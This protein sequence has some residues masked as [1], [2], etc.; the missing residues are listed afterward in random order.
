[1]TSHFLEQLCISNK[2][3]A[4]ILK[5]FEYLLIVIAGCHLHHQRF[6]PSD[7]ARQA[8]WSLVGSAHYEDAVTDAIK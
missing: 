8:E 7:H 3:V 6:C 5:Q 4:C 2:A 1:M